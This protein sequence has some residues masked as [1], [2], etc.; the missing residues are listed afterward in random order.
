MGAVP[1][2]S[3]VCTALVIAGPGG[4]LPV[5]MASLHKIC[6]PCGEVPGCLLAG[7]FEMGWKGNINSK[8]SEDRCRPYP[9]TLAKHPP[10]PLS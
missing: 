7:H 10:P 1:L 9:G 4:P 3:H 8:E 2:L 5:T 6:Q